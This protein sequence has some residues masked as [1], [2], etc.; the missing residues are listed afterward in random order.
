MLNNEEVITFLNAFESVKEIVNGSEFWSA[1]NLMKILGYSQWHFFAPVIG[2][3][4]NNFDSIVIKLCKDNGYNMPGDS[5]TCKSHQMFNIN[6]N[7]LPTT[8]KV[9]SGDRG[10]VREY[11]DYI[12]TKLACYAIIMEADNNKPMVRLGKRYFLASTIENEEDRNNYIE[13]KQRLEYREAMTNYENSLESTYARHGVKPSNFGVVKSA[14]DAGFY[15]NPGGTRAVKEEM[16]IPNNK[17]LYDYMDYETLIH[18]SMANIYT[19]HAIINKNLNGTQECAS[20]AFDQNK[21]QREHMKEMT[22]QYPEDTMPVERIGSVKKGIKQANHNA[23]YDF[24]NNT[25]DNV[26][27]RL[28][29]EFSYNGFT[30]TLGHWCHINDIDPNYTLSLIDNGVPFEQAIFMR[31]NDMVSPLLFMR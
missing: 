4:M 26:D 17:P 31:Q 19:K 5:C 10:T 28:F 6:A 8:R 29:G 11:P 24:V 15:N 20:E 23:I 27:P 13:G 7:F 1:S 16:G 22:G 12:L 3:A 25:P 9:K 18:K 14:G 21:E 30:Y 2:K